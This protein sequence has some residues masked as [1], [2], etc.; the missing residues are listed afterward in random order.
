MIRKFYEFDPG[1]G[2]PDEMPDKICFRLDTPEKVE[3]AN[4][5]REND[6]VYEMSGSSTFDFYFHIPAHCNAINDISYGCHMGDGVKPGYTLVDDVFMEKYY[7]PWDDARKRNKAGAKKYLMIS[8]GLCVQPT[9]EYPELDNFSMQQV[10]FGPRF[11]KTAYS[12]AVQDWVD[13]LCEIPKLPTTCTLPEGSWFEGEEQKQRNYYAV[14]WRPVSDL[15]FDRL[16]DKE[17]RKVIVP[18]EQKDVE[19]SQDWEGLINKHIAPYFDGDVPRDL[20]SLLLN[21]LSEQANDLTSEWLD[22]SEPS[23]SWAQ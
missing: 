2:G 20:K 3:Y 15:V 23:K 18:V 9:M 4:A 16:D 1:M 8:P 14:G 21:M 19:A 6:R 17:R 11:D 7:K 13:H 22:Y 12:V 10:F 5:H